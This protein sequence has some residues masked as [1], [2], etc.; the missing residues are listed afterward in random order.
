MKCFFR[1]TRGYIQE[2]KAIYAKLIEAE[3]TYMNTICSDMDKKHITHPPA[4]PEAITKSDPYIHTSAINRVREYLLLH[5]NGI[6]PKIHYN[7]LDLLKYSQPR[8]I[9]QTGKQKGQIWHQPEAYHFLFEAVS[10]IRY[11]SLEETQSR[12]IIDFRMSDPQ[13]SLITLEV[14]FEGTANGVQK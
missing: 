9:R 2:P 3:K 12:H 10:V 14:S 7:V 11:V 13:K 8:Y 5:D 6:S 1:D 4:D